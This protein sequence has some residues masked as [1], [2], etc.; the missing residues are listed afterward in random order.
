MKSLREN[1]AVDL[2]PAHNGSLT[3]TKE[4][5]IERALREVGI[6]PPSVMD[7][8]YGDKAE[9]T[10]AELIVKSLEE[11]DLLS[12]SERDPRFGEKIRFIPV[13]IAELQRRLPDGEITTC[14]AF[15]LLNVGC[16][17]ICHTDPLHGMN[18]VEL[19]GCNWAWL[20]CAVDA[21]NS[22][23]PCLILHEQEQDSPEGKMWTCK[24]RNGG[25]RED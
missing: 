10:K 20:C 12:F 4:E 15:S 23:E 9:M 13:V 1:P 2:P 24:Y 14:G 5:L 21:A 8:H 16:C 11:M 18:L 3:M 19:P 6:F 25:R 7:R 17:N 22:P